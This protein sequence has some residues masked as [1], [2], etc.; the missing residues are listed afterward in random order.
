VAGRA[1]YL[2]LTIGQARQQFRE[3][4]RR[5][6]VSYGKQVIF[7]PVETLLCLAASFQI[8]HRRFGG[9]TA[10]QAPEPVPSLA[11]GWEQAVADCSGA[12]RSNGPS[13]TGGSAA[14]HRLTATCAAAMT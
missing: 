13:G 5:S 11:D 14:D 9:A 3:L 4:M 12:R 1:D 7:L 2:E 10:H 8:N 6:P